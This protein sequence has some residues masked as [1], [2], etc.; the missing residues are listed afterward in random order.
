M[1]MGNMTRIAAALFAKLLA[2]DVHEVE[3]SECNNHAQAW[4]TQAGRVL[5]AM[6]LLDDEDDPEVQA[7][8]GAL[9]GQGEAWVLLAEQGHIPAEVVAHVLWLVSDQEEGWPGPPFVTALLRTIDRAA[10]EQREITMLA[11]PEY[12]GLYNAA[13]F[14]PYGV[15]RLTRVWSEHRRAVDVIAPE[16]VE[17]A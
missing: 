5:H 12:V 11:F 3:R 4:R 17:P 14:L 16:D 1:Y 7:D 8:S 10:A 15:A 6:D 2:G 13:M 9:L